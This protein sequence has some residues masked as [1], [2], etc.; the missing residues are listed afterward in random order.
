[1]NDAIAI[2]GVDAAR[3]MV[4]EPLNAGLISIR[5]DYGDPHVYS[6]ITKLARQNMDGLLV[7]HFDDIDAPH[8][9][10]Q[11]PQMH[12]VKRALA[13]ARKHPHVIV[14]CTAG[15]SRSSAIALMI[16]YDRL[17]DVDAA[18]AI[19]DCVRHFPNRIVVGL[20][21]ELFGVD[22]G[23]YAQD[24]RISDQIQFTEREIEPL[25]DERADK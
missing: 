10:F 19:L 24:P 6:D 11:V 17:R 3:L 1:M 21:E 9:G 16:A 5:D 25:L 18:K 23:L 2:I 22:F 7:L 4:E 12:H 8:D 13:F 14:H 20:G 15:I